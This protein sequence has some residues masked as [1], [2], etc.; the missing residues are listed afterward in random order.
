[1]LIPFKAPALVLSLPGAQNPFNQLSA[2]LHINLSKT[3]TF[4]INL[5][6]ILYLL[7]LVNGS[8]M[9]IVIQAS[10]FA[11]R[12]LGSEFWL[13]YHLLSVKTSARYLT[14]SCLIF[15]IR[16]WRGEKHLPHRTVWIKRDKCSALRTMQDT[17]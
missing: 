15:F 10:I 12:Q 17:L 1:M 4:T 16:K 11:L 9:H 2:A 14:S 5:T 3:N 7:I 13:I 8:S 6:P